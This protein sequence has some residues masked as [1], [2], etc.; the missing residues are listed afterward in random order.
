M[1]VFDTRKKVRNVVGEDPETRQREGAPSLLHEGAG[2]RDLTE[3][4]TS[5]R[6]GFAAGVHLQ[7]WKK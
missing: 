7:I 4:W 6:K 1:R 5:I 2:I 3:W